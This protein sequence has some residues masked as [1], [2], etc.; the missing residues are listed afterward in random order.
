MIDQARCDGGDLSYWAKMKMLKVKKRT[1]IGWK[2]I[3]SFLKKYVVK[4][5]LINDG[6]VSKSS[7]F[8]LSYQRYQGC[9]IHGVKHVFLA[10]A[11]HSRNDQFNLSQ[12]FGVRVRF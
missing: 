1:K 2:A 10:Q 8:E 5:L 3:T 12:L 7:S 9:R 4:K 11:L 6:S